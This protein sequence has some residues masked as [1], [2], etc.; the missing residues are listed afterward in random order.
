MRVAPLCALDTAAELAGHRLDQHELLVLLRA[1]FRE[2]L[3]E[4]PVECVQALVHRLEVRVEPA[5]D[6]LVEDG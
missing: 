6:G 1:Q 5:R 3:I 4:A 2:A